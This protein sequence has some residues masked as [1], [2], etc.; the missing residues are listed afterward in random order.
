MVTQK[1]EAGADSA[2]LVVGLGNPG[3]AYSRHRHNVG[4][5]VVDELAS[6]LGGSLRPHKSRRA[7]VLEAR[8]PTSPPGHRVV[9]GRAR[10][11]MNETGGSVS[12]LLSFYRLQVDRLIVVHDEL[13]IDFPTLRVKFGGGDNGH[14][15]LRSVRSAIGSGDFMRVR[16]G[17]GR[18][19]TQQPVADFVLSPYS[20]AER[21]E[22]P[23]QVS[24]AADAVVSL[25]T[26]GL[27]ATQNS[28]NAGL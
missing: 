27:S 18:P 19:T 4:Y 25:I 6:R 10:S 2:W 12:T 8:V 17:I 23:A 7:D 3:V 20:G 1:S 9:I 21:A 15:G 14:N 11:Y 5:L 16:V 24:R 28:F 13:D 26:N 22:L